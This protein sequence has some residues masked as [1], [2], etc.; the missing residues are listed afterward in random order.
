MPYTSTLKGWST[1][2]VFGSALGGGPGRRGSYF[3]GYCGPYLRPVFDVIPPS[4]ARGVTFTR[5]IS[6]L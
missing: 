2:Q 5:P 3:P 6:A 4:S 1:G